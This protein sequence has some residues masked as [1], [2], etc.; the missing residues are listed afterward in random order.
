[1]AS[2]IFKYPSCFHAMDANQLP[3]SWILT[4]VILLLLPWAHSTAQPGAFGG[5]FRFRIYSDK[6]EI[7]GPENSDYL[8]QVE[9]RAARDSFSY[10]GKLRMFVFIPHKTPA[11]AHVSDEFRIKIVHKGKSMFVYPPSFWRVPIVL[12]SIRFNPGMYKIPD[13]IYSIYE[14]KAFGEPSVP[15]IKGDWKFFNSDPQF[16]C[17]ELVEEYSRPTDWKTFH[18]K[19][20]KEFPHPYSINGSPDRSYYKENLLFR[21]DKSSYFTIYE[22]K[23]IVT[24]SLDSSSTFYDFKVDTVLFQNGSYFAIGFRGIRISEQEELTYGKFKLHFYQ[25][26]SAA[27]KKCLEYKFH[28]DLS[29]IMKYRVKYGGTGNPEYVKKIHEERFEEYKM[30]NAA[31]IGKCK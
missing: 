14:T 4:T 20:S 29:E 22:I 31:D 25:D 1:M 12:D 3:F 30:R 19:Y 8:V 18:K 21:L 11:G 26:L 24:S 9:N 23:E 7:V 10:S 17:L 5:D 16:V 6:N 15:N 27:A 28:K 2:R 13:Y